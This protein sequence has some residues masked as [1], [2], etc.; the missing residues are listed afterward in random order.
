MA[1][2]AFVV[3]KEVFHHSNNNILRLWEWL[4]DEKE[5]FLSKFSN[6]NKHL[7]LERNFNHLRLRY[8]DPYNF[9]TKCALGEPTKHVYGC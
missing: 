5:F 8:P 9:L 4:D 3:A 6:I 2:H 1:G 7:Y